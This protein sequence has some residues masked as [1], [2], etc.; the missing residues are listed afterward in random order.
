VSTDKRI[1]ICGAGPSGLSLAIFLADKGYRPRII[2]KK[3]TVSPYSKAFAVNPRSLELLDEAGITKRFI[4][5]GR[6]MQAMNIWKNHQLFFRNEFSNIKHKFPFLLIQSQRESELILQE[7]TR[8]R[9]IEIEFGTQL[10][11]LTKTP[12]GYSSTLQKDDTFTHESDIIVAADGSRS[13]VRTQSGIDFPGFGYRGT[14]ELYDVEL[15]IDIPEDDANLFFFNT[16]GM[17]LIRIKNNLWRIAGSMPDLLNYLPKGTKVGNIPWQ[18]KF[19]IGHHIAQTL[20]KDNVVLIGDAAHIHSPFGGRGMNL[21]VEDAYLCANAIHNNQLMH[22]SEV[23]R[24]YLQKTVGRINMLT[25]FVTADSGM[26]LFMKKTAWLAKP[27]LPLLRPAMRGF[28]SGM[29]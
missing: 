5:N 9:G 8:R 24:P 12:D 21:G 10:L 2:D 16:G 23:R 7:E 3:Q 27:F 14:W 19:N 17:I 28:V 18:A 26:R 22:Y 25:S 13:E 6:K 20:V 11:D 29:N 15:D 4:E 1:L